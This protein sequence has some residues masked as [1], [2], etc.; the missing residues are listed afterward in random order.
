MILLDT[1]HVGVLGNT[2]GTTGRRL[3]A[4][5]RAANAPVAIPIV[6]VEEQMR[7]WMASIAKERQVAR[8]V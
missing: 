8:Q 6:A 2:E 7:G 3:A 1:N 4:R 5:L